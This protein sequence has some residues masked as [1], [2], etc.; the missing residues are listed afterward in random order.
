MLTIEQ[1]ISQ[2]K[3]KDKLD[4]FNFTNHAENMTAVLKYVMDY[5]NNYLNP[6]AYDYEKIKIEQT[7]SKIEQEIENSFPNSKGFIIDYYKKYKTRIDRNL[8]SW[9]KDLK[10]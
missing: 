4:E 1:Y 10:Y 3:K 7:A 5:F 9:M 8:K 6:E 2:M